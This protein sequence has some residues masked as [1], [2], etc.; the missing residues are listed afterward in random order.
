MPLHLQCFQFCFHF[1]ASPAAFTP[2]FTSTMLSILLPLPRFPCCRHTRFHIYS[3]FN[4]ASLSLAVFP[5]LSPR[6]LLQLQ[7]FQLSFQF[8]A[9]PSDSTSAFT[10]T[11]LS[12][13]HFP[14]NSGRAIASRAISP[15]THRLVLTQSAEATPYI[16][17]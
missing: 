6:P 4:F 11:A 16:Q 13:S 9:S 7:C 5:L 14:D 3:A 12:I 2:A 10:I 17:S 8:P 15:I 1:P